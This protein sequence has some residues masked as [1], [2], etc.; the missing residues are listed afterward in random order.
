L[1]EQEIQKKTDLVEKLDQLIFHNEQRAKSLFNNF[2]STHPKDI[3][4]SIKQYK[5]L[6]VHISGLKKQREKLATEIKGETYTEKSSFRL[7]GGENV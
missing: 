5:A 1:L 6:V 4:F 2:L 3:T 7:V